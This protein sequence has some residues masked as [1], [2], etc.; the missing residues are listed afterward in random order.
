MKRFND[1]KC[2]LDQEN[3]ESFEKRAQYC[4]SFKSC[5]REGKF[6]NSECAKDH[7][8]AQ[9]KAGG[10]WRHG[11]L[12]AKYCDGEHKVDGETV[13]FICN[14]YDERSTSLKQK[15]DS[16]KTG[17]G[18]TTWAQFVTEMKKQSNLEYN[19]NFKAHDSDTCENTSFN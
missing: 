5:Y 7:V 18:T 6:T 17:S 15:G 14:V 16:Y 3:N 1:S 12:I 4:S 19:E 8:C 10:N 11:C 13:K 9:W 2:T